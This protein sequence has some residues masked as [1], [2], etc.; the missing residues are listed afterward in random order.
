MCLAKPIHQ[1]AQWLSIFVI[2]VCFSTS[3]YT[4]PFTCDGDF[5]LAF[6][7]EGPSSVYRM[8]IAPGTGAVALNPLP[9]ADAGAVINAMGYRRTDNYIYGIDPQTFDLYRIDATGTATFLT[10]LPL[11]PQAIYWA[12]AVTPDG[13]ELL[14]LG[15]TNGSICTCDFARVNLDDYTVN[16]NWIPNP[17]NG[18]AHDFIITDMAFDP[19]TGGLFGFDNEGNRLVTI[20][21]DDGFIDETIYPASD[22]ADGLG[23]IFFDPFGNIYG[24]GTPIS[25]DSAN[26]L[27]TIDKA[28]GIAE[29]VATGPATTGQDG[30]SCSYTI[31]LRKTVAPQVSIPCSDLTFV[32]EIANASSVDQGGIDFT[33]VMP[34]E[35]T[36]TGIVK[37]P[38][39]GNIV[40]GIGSNTLSITGMTIPEGIDSIIVTAQANAGVAGLFFNQASLTNLP[41]D[42]GGETVS[43]NPMTIVVDDSTS[44]RIIPLQPNLVSDTVGLC[45]NDAVDLIALTE[46]VSYL[47]DDG[48]TDQSRTVTEPGVYWVEVFSDCESVV[49]TVIALDQS[50]TV[51]LGPDL[52]INLGDSIL[53][54]PFV[55]GGTVSLY[56]W[57]DPLG[58][59]LTCSTCPNTWAK[60]SFDATFQLH[61]TDIYGCTDQDD[62]LIRVNKNRNVFIPNV[63]SPNQD[64]I[65]DHFFIQGQGTPEV[66]ELTVFDRWG[67]VVFNRKG[68]AINDPQQGWDGTTG[69]RLASTGVYTYMARLQY[70]DGEVTVFS[71]DVAVVR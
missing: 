18:S 10:N 67:T 45:G 50:V 39:G 69:E 2:L 27:F 15:K 63:F 57:T 20:N 12:G 38:F 1:Y 33:D 24:Y 44:V 34:A 64:G 4:Q 71:G 8:V 43:D 54:I 19:Q 26:T 23:A 17:S 40:S 22:V 59:A 41:T 46:G 55:T 32:F 49:D 7:R 14:L 5:I 62:L 29:I 25:G 56:D 53:L 68:G 47:W 60:P 52:E 30:C 70:A 51:D 11:T 35:F 36:I 37:N 21:P 42:L 13:Q 58:T 3:I 66:L 6:N 61:V 16:I 9:A 65:N 31:D 48:S 28:T